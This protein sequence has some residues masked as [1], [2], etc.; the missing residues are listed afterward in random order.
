MEVNAEDKYA[1]YFA[2][3]FK[4]G[5]EYANFVSLKDERIPRR[6]IR[7]RDSRNKDQSTFSVIVRV[8]RKDLEQKLINDNILKK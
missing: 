5:G 4:D 1:T 6:I 8:L 7:E 3:F 2:N